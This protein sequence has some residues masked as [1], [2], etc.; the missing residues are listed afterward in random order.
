MSGQ[1]ASLRLG[2]DHAFMALRLSPAD[3]ATMPEL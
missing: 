1:D 3:T 2:H